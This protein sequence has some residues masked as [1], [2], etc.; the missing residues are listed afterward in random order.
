MG[1]L[2]NEP[3]AQRVFLIG[4]QPRFDDQAGDLGLARFLSPRDNR[5]DHARASGTGD[6][7]QEATHQGG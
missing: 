7:T 5:F 2:C 6:T 3:L 4:K 1:K